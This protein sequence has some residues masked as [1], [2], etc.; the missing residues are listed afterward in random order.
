MNQVWYCTSKAIAQI[1]IVFLTSIYDE[2]NT[3]NWHF[4]KVAVTRLFLYDNMPPSA[5]DKVVTFAGEVAFERKP[6]TSIKPEA[7]PG[8]RIEWLVSGQPEEL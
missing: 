7:T 2:L 3:Q 8:D 1:M 4:I 5:L 6:P